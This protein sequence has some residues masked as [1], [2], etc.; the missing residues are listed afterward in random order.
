MN[1]KFMFLDNRLYEYVRGF[2]RRLNRPVQHA[3]NPIMEP[4]LPHEFNRVLLYGSVVHD[5]EEG[6]FRMWYSSSTQRPKPLSHLLYAESDDGYAWRRPSLDVVPGTNIVMED[7]RK[8]H[9]PTV[10]LDRD[11][12]DEAKRYKMIARRGRGVLAGYVS[13]D[14]IHW[15]L[16]RDEPL[17]H[18]DSDSH[19][20]LFRDPE[21]GRYHASF[22]D[23]CPD[24]RV[25]R[26]ESEDFLAWRRPVLA[27]EPDIRDPVQTQFYSL[28]MTPYGACVLGWLHRYT[29][30][31]ADLGP[32]KMNGNWDIELAFSRGGY[33][34]HR[35]A[36]G[37]NFLPRDPAG[38]TAGLISPAS[39]PLFFADEIR[40]YFAGCEKQ[41]GDE[42]ASKRFRIG[43]ASLK[44]DRFLS[45]DAGAEPAEVLTR[46]FATRSP[47]LFL[48]AAAAGGGAVRA[49]LRDVGGAPIPGY[50]LHN[51][52]PVEADATAAP[53]RW[54]GNP[55][56]AAFLE[57][58]IR[59]YLSAARAS[60]Y[61]A[62]FADGATIG[63]Y[64]NFK[65]IRCLRP[66]HDLA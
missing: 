51:C 6:R 28:Q 36:Q 26:S 32:T 46:A 60:L 52:V 15:E 11:E 1:T 31:E 7:D 47:A 38:W 58:P 66:E 2:R 40:F 65:E 25:W 44:P 49:E 59:L 18:A 43:V 30:W 19:I 27:L 5:P 16:V 13:P 62:T 21:S 34:W 29:T 64:R 56:P 37:E 53:V 35:P 14:G 55:S 22:R 42:Y 17:I 20:G 10:I 3:G 63:D 41:H 12:P 23:A 57:K 48:N 33:C 4:E 45:L 24:R 8:I 54:R 9:G 50:E 39:A 61:S